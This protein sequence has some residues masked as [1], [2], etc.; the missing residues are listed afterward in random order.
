MEGRDYAYV[1]LVNIKAIDVSPEALK[2]VHYTES[3]E[4]EDGFTYLLDKNGNV[5]KDS[6]GNDIKIPKHKTIT[7]TIVETQQKKTAL[8]TGTLDY[9]NNESNQLMKTDPI[10]AQAFFENYFATASGDL[11]AL[12]DSTKKKIGNK[13]IP[14]PTNPAMILSLIHI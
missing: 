4:I 8:I 3:K 14:F 1:I 11:T 13:F 2:E 10:T 12:S 7:C 9:L 5:V 6:L